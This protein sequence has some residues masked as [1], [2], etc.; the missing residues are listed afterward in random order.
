MAKIVPSDPQSAADYEDRTTKAVKSVLVE[1]GQILGS[2]KGK[3]AV[4]GG[5]VPWLLLDN[6][7]MPHVGTLDVDLGLDPEALGDGEYVTLVEALM[8]QGYKQREELRRFQLVREVPVD[9][10]G[11]PIDIVVDFLMPRDAEIVK[12]RPPIL[13]DF[14]VQRADGA[15]LALRF[16][17]LVAISGDMP[18]GGTNRVEIA[19]CSIPALLAMKGYALNGRH[20]QKD[21]YD[22]YYCI[23]NY[24]DGIEALAEAC[25]PLL[26]HESGAQGYKYIADKFDTA[27][28]Y[29]ATSV[30]KFVAETDI[31]DG[32]TPEQWQQDAFGQID[33]WLRALGLRG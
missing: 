12:N 2:F 23:R 25:K 11:T 33:A 29:G 30:R 9:D 14:A 18:E 21:A 5:A 20:K 19:V 4:I 24:P 31:L 27:E 3:F 32:R 7:D 10:G 16:Y 26:E 1:I 22:I 17:Q 8:A 6:E 15:D 28:G 13:S